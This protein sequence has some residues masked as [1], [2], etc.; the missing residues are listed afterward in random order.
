MEI[1]KPERLNI[2]EYVSKCL[3]TRLLEEANDTQKIKYTV[4][5]FLS[6]FFLLLFFSHICVSPLSMRTIF[7]LYTP[8]TS[9]PNPPI[10][11]NKFLLVTPVLLN[12]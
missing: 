8:F 3:S 9:H 12:I 7:L 5:Y 2:I 10:L 1:R 4:H 11:P 6:M